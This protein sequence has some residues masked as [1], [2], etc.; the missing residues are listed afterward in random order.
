MST[1]PACERGFPAE[2]RLQRLGD[3]GLLGLV[4]RVGRSQYDI[5]TV[6][7]LGLELVE[8]L[9]YVAQN[10]KPAVV[11][12]QPQQIAEFVRVF[13]SAGSYLDSHIKYDSNQCCTVDAGSADPQRYLRV[14]H[15]FS[16]S[17]Q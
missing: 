14:S 1:P 13:N 17:V 16:R 11:S 5:D 7:H 3:T 12:Q 9:C 4:Y 6:L 10:R 8:P 2:A 15:D